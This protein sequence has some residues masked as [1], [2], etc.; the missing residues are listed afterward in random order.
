MY[1]ATRKY[2][3][4]VFGRKHGKKTYKGSIK[5]GYEEQR[6]IASELL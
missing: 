3:D 1:I 4:S 2:L 6:D 5:G